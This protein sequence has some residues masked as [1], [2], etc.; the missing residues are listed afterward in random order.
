MRLETHA[1]ACGILELAAKSDRLAHGIHRDDLEV[2][3]AR[4]AA[5]EYDA[6]PLL[7]PID[8]PGDSDHPDPPAV[9]ATD[10]RCR[11]AVENREH[12]GVE[13]APLGVE[14]SAVRDEPVA[15]LAARA[16]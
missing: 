1:E 10:G 11:R 7:R 8:P 5:L 3:V 12:L 2:P 4:L 13:G 9:G 14:Q 6:P 15:R 16:W